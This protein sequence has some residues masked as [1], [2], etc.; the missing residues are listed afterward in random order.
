MRKDKPLIDSRLISPDYC[1]IPLTVLRRRNYLTH[2]EYEMD[3]ANGIE[4]A[5]IPELDY[6]SADD[7][8]VSFCSEF[9][10]HPFRT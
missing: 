4:Q 2:D 5:E 6:G 8:S 3:L 9:D 10:H 7:P 1:R